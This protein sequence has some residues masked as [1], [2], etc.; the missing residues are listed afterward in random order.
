MFASRPFTRNCLSFPFN[1]AH[2][3]IISVVSSPL[4]T[5]GLVKTGYEV[6]LK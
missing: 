1:A 6:S 5:H 2:I 3:Q 4:V